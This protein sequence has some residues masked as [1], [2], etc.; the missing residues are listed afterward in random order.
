MAL[1]RSE[2]VGRLRA[3]VAAGSELAVDIVQCYARGVR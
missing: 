2:V 3:Q 1:S